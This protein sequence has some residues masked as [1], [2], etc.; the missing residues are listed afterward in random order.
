MSAPGDV[1]DG[2]GILCDARGAVV[3]REDSYHPGGAKRQRSGRHAGRPP[4]AEGG[5]GAGRVSRRK[6][7]D[8]AGSSA[9]SDWHCTA[10]HQKRRTGGAG[11]SG[12]NAAR[13]GHAGGFSIAQPGDP[14]IWG[15]HGVW[16]GKPRHGR[17]DPA[18][19]GCRGKAARLGN[20]PEIN[21]GGPGR[22]AVVGRP[23]FSGGLSHQTTLR[24]H[25]P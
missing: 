22:R 24:P 11:L 18:D 4:G 12:W 17:S 15:A 8:G 7:R 23:R 10:G 6:S 19:S 16:R 3:L 13:A 20:R 21:R 25:I 2:A 9:V 14:A 1:D 5:K